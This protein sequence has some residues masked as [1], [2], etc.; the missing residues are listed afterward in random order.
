M[1]TASIVL[2][3]TAQVQEKGFPGMTILHDI[4][5]LSTRTCNSVSH[6]NMKEGRSQ[7]QTHTLGWPFTVLLG[8]CLGTPKI[9]VSDK[10]DDITGCRMIDITLY[11]DTIYSAIRRKGEG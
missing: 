3:K 6:Y 1:Q 11:K 10:L 7:M 5:L 9:Y 2:T 8:V 4:S